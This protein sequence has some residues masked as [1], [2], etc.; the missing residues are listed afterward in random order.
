M[1]TDEFVVTY[2]ILNLYMFL[3]FVFFWLQ[4]KKKDD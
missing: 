1:V 2:L 4:G 3:S